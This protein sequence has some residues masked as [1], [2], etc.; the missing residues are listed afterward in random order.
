MKPLHFILILGLFSCIACEEDNLKYDDRYLLEGYVEININGIGIDGDQLDETGRLQEYRKGYEDMY[1]GY[2]E[3]AASYYFSFGRMDANDDSKEIL[4]YFE[5]DKNSHQV[6][7]ASFDARYCTKLENGN[8]FV[9]DIDS[10]DIDEI[11]ITNVSFDTS[12]NVLRGNYSIMVI[13]QEGTVER[14]LVVSGKFSG[15]VRKI[16][17]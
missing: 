9:L 6:S 1:S 4:I 17:K 7:N 8:L 12:E 3:T 10:T 16:S 2:R 13:L 15:V 14:T 11:Q 5:Y